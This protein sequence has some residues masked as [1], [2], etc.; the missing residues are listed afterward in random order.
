MAYILDICVVLILLL[1]NIK[2]ATWNATGIISS[3]S[4]LCDLLNDRAVDVCGISEHFLYPNNVHFLSTLN[5]DYRF[6]VT[7]DR[8]LKLPGARRVGKGGVCL[9]WHKRYDNYIVP[10]HTDDDRIIGIQF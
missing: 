8:D 9:T 10:L 2:L 6:H 5:S 3:A 7:C 1:M 4:Y